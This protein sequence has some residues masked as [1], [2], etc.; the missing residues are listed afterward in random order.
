MYI[1]A[2]LRAISVPSMSKSAAITTG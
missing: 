1:G 2:E